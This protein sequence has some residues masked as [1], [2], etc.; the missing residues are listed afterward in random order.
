MA[1]DAKSGKLSFY[2][3]TLTLALA[4]GY[5]VLAVVRGYIGVSAVTSNQVGWSAGLFQGDPLLGARLSSEVDGYEILRDRRIPVLTDSYGNRACN[6][7][8]ISDAQSSQAEVLF[9]GDSFTFGAAVDVENTF[10]AL[11]AAEAGVSF[12]NAG[13]P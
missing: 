13:V 3:I 9:L 8:A 1:I 6:R 12:H 2:I 11:L 7:C 5:L 4:L 10:P